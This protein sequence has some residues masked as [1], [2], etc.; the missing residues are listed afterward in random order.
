MFVDTRMRSSSPDYDLDDGGLYDLQS[1][2]DSRAKRQ[3]AGDLSSSGF[4]SRLG[5]RFPTLSQKWRNKRAGKTTSIVDSL[6]DVK[7]S[8]SRANST[9]ASSLM[10]SE[11]DS[12]S[13]PTP[14]RSIHDDQADNINSPAVDVPSAE[15]HNEE[16]EPEMKA[17]T[18]LLP[19]IMT[20][21]SSHLQE[22]PMQSPLQSPTIADQDL[23][24]VAHTPI[25]HTPITSP[26]L[27]GLP[28]PP[29]S[30]RPSISSFHR[31]PLLPASEIP[32]HPQG[33]YNHPRTHKLRHP[34]I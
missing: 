23:P 32:P 15:A 17:S 10:G 16:A 5:T 33:S 25:T 13:P 7:P 24:S 3:R 9:R 18:P 4:T 11:K 21:I 1:A 2:M 6:Q 20:N 14:A 28:S 34:N 30:T 27:P 31:H 22:V 8:R 12:Q 19:P 29:L 26:Q